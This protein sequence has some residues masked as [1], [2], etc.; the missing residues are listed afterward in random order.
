MRSGSI[1]GT[2]AGRTVANSPSSFLMLSSRVLMA[3]RTAVEGSPSSR[4]LT[5]FWSFL[6]SL[7]SSLA[8]AFTR[9]ISATGPLKIHSSL[10]N[11][12]LRDR[13]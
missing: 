12:L 5:R 1:V 9:S 11:V 7:S 4:A 6:R 8:M 3:E 10:V 13:T 2:L